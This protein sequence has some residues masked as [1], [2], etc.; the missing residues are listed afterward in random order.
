VSRCISLSRRVRDRAKSRAHAIQELDRLPEP[1]TGIDAWVSARCDA[2]WCCAPDSNPTQPS[3]Y[4]A[5]EPAESDTSKVVAEPDQLAYA[6][7]GDSGSWS[8]DESITKA[9]QPSALVGHRG[10]VITTPVQ[11]GPRP[12]ICLTVSTVPMATTTTSAP[13]MG[14]KRRRRQR[15][16]RP[17]S[18][19]AGIMCG[20]VYSARGG[21]DRPVAGVPSPEAD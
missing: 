13:T 7:V 15:R 4:T 11:F 3:R 20:E 8:S 1:G 18:P 17:P 19:D 12:E 2:D 21:M 10:T 5:Y 14:A 9:R 6:T 16:C